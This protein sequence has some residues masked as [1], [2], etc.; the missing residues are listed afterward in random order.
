MHAELLDDLGEIQGNLGDMAGARQTLERALA[1]ASEE[2][3]ADSV[4]VAR[5]RR[6]LAQLVAQAGDFEEAKEQGERALAAFERMGPEQAVE[7]ARVKLVLAIALIN[8]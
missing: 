4:E 1:L 5:T 3:G 6:K 2:H 8:S 7:A